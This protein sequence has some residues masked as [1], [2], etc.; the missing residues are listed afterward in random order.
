MQKWGPFVM[1]SD[2]NN[3]P[4]ISWIYAILFALCVTTP[5]LALVGIKILITTM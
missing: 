4:E 2:Y 3:S 5:I 1:K